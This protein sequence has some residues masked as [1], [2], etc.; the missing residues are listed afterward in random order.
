MKKLFTFLCLLVAILAPV[1]MYCGAQENRPISK[2]FADKKISI[3]YNNEDLIDIINEIAS[4]KDVN[5]ILPLGANAI[6]QKITWH[7]D[8]PVSVNEAWELLQTILNIADYSITL[9]GDMYAIVKNSKAI[10]KEVLPLYIGTEPN[11]IPDTDDRIRLLYYLANIK[12]S[13]QP[14]SDLRT[15]LETYLPTDTQSFLLEPRTNAIIITDRANVIKS[16]MRIVTAL[17]KVTFQER[18][19]ITKLRYTSATQL[20]TLF[21]D[22]LTPSDRNVLGSKGKSESLY[23]SEN[24]KLIPEPRTNSLII[25]GRGA[26]VDRIAEFIRQ[27]VDVPIESGNSVLHVYQ[28]LYLDASLFATT[29][30]NI[31]RAEKASGTGQSTAATG[32]GGVERYFQGVIVK[33]DQPTTGA[34]FGSNKL[35]IAANSDDWKHIK[36]LIEQLDHPQP[37]VIIE[38]LVA[39]LTMDDLRTL[40]T[41][42][43]NPAALPMPGLMNIQ[44]AQIARVVLDLPSAANPTGTPTTIASDLLGEV[45]PVTGGG[46]TS[47]AGLT[48]VGLG[49]PGQPESTLISI[50][51]PGTGSTWGLLQILKGFTTTKIL[52]HPHVITTNNK[53]AVVSI[54]QQR[55]LAGEATATAAAPT[56]K[57]DLVNA[58]LTVTI[59]PR[60]SAADSVNLQVKI[61]A[62]D[63]EPGA[64]GQANVRTDRML[65]TNAFVKSND[66]LALGGLIRVATADSIN[67]TPLLSKIPIL[68]WLFKARASQTIKT[69]LTVFISPTIIQPRLRRGIDRYTKEYVEL[70]GTYATE[71]QLF[72]GLRD[73]ITR[74]FFRTQ[75]Y[76]AQ[77]S[78]A[79]FMAKDELKTNTDILP[80]ARMTG[81]LRKTDDPLGE[82]NQMVREVRAEQARVQAERPEPQAP[83]EE[84]KG[85]VLPEDKQ[86]IITT[87]P[88]TT[89]K[90]EQLKKMLAGE[91][92][93]LINRR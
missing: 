23:F 29:L 72:E 14:K 57:T 87:A 68:G 51:D 83:A 11:D 60:I 73:P 86:Q 37:Q 21:K 45:V 28:L 47:V 4:A 50:S 13:D 90:D 64:A 16:V 61:S 75:D 44:S 62:A 39:D 55:L 41:M 63:F 56:I 54:G 85:P 9:R 67:E 10:S 89:T 2:R 42:L 36:R 65:Q 35:I 27:Y 77:A 34:S 53:Q 48:G 91:D 69:N 74:F 33:A 71:S 19:E 25:V 46:F 79:E 38:I 88:I 52:S 24:V 92:N 32:G 58:N 8:N 76:D 93:P 26:T 82:R 43:R 78:I 80:N 66:I 12:V 30:Q 3:H 18:I 22:I 5:I 7:L 15:I 59:T 6:S 17:D 81:E 20:A 84:P 70:S 31:V 40:G 49:N 1:V